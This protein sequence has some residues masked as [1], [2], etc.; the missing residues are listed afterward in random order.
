MP[1]LGEFVRGGRRAASP[2]LQPSNGVDRKAI[3]ANSK[4]KAGQIRLNNQPGH[5]QQSLQRYRLGEEI[6]P[7]QHVNPLHQQEGEGHGEF[8]GGVKRDPWDTDVES[9]DTTQNGLNL[10]HTEDKQPS[11]RD[12]EE[13]YDGRDEYG[14]DEDV[15]N[16]LEEPN[17]A[18]AVNPEGIR[19]VLQGINMARSTQ[20]HLNRQFNLPLQERPQER[21]SFLGGGDSYPTTTSGRPDDSFPQLE[22]VSSG[23][24]EQRESSPPPPPLPPQRQRAHEEIERLSSPDPFSPSA[25]ASHPAD[26]MNTMRNIYQKGAAIRQTHRPDPALSFR[27]ERAQENFPSR[28]PPSQTPRHETTAQV[29]EPSVFRLAAPL[30]EPRQNPRVQI[31]APVP[32]RGLARPQNPVPQP[33]RLVQPTVTL[34]VQTQSRSEPEAT[35]ENDYDDATLFH[36]HYE[37]LKNESFDFDPNAGPPVLSEDMQRK[38]LHDRLEHVHTSLAVDDQA[39][40]FTSLPAAEWE[41]SGDW[42][43]ER[44]QSIILKMKETRQQKRRLAQEFECEIEKRHDHVAKKQRQ[45]ENSMGKMRNQGQVLLPKSPRKNRA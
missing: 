17:D 10:M 6:R 28:V 40:F 38:S 44:F 16:H 33:I 19:H 23:P 45:V 2:Q 41:D 7:S 36:K 26:E 1:K 3:A 37:A 43:L 12:K 39:R 27:N 34:P 25:S 4:V 21:S 30:N 31:N 13:F 20:E 5:Q 29:N 9:I 8:G 18:Q 14:Y 42:F 11:I 32:E 24:V 22:E 15:V 35:V